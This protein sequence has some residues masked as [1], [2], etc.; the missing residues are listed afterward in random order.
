MLFSRRRFSSLKA[1]NGTNL[2]KQL[3]SLGRRRIIFG[4]EDKPKEEPKGTLS[5]KTLFFKG[6]TRDEPKEK[7][8]H[9]SKETPF[10]TNREKG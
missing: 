7:L 9:F 2:K 4:G 8:R 1:G 3:R 5:R 10:F 6:G